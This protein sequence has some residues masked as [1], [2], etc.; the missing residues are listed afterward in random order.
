MYYHKYLNINIKHYIQ[1]NNGL[2]NQHMKLSSLQLLIFFSL[3]RYKIK[4]TKGFGYSE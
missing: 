4:S 1:I 2:K 3:V